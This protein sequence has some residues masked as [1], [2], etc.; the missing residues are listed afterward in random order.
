M[1][2]YARYDVEFAR[3]EEPAVGA[4]GTEDLDF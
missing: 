3:G 4:D 1:P 2:T